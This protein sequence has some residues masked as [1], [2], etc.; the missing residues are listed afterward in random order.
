[1][2]D[3]WASNHWNLMWFWRHYGQSYDRIWSV[4]YDVRHAGPGLDILWHIAPAADY[5]VA[6]GPFR[7]GDNRG[8]DGPPNPAWIV[9]DYYCA[10]RQVA[11]YSARFLAGVDRA[12]RAG[13]HGQDEILL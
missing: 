6:R 7:N 5:I 1:W 10:M 13:I 2:R 3:A 8:M 4:E 12:L 11:A 9:Y